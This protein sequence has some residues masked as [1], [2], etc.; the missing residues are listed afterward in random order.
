[1]KRSSE[2]IVLELRKRPAE[3]VLSLNE[4]AMIREIQ[5]IYF[6]KEKEVI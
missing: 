3:K 5:F 1:M 2:D 6:K 4:L